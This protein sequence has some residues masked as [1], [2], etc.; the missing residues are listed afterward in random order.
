[1]RKYWLIFRVAISE[2]LVYRADF[3]ISTF[4]RF[5]PIITTVLLWRAIYDGSGRERVGNLSYSEMV[6]YYLFVMIVRA[7]GSMPRLATDVATDIRDG[8][9][10]RYLLQPIDYVLYSM[11]LR[12]AHKLVYFV[13]AAGP[14]AI[15]FWMCRQYLPGWPPASTLAVS[16][17]TLTLAFLLGFSIS[18]SLGLLGFWFLE[19]SSFIH[20]FMI[21]QYFLGGHMFPLS[22]LPDSVRTVLMWLPFAYETYYPTVILLQR[23]EPAEI[24]RIIAM[25]VMWVITLLIF[26]RIAWWRGLR[27]YAAFGG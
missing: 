19:V 16:L 6:S 14:Y 1:M 3:F 23:V 17:V 27:R 5:I 13:M 12:A 15:V 2:R 22:L 8:G 4:L 25:Q 9:L 18:M 7:F 21:V 11:V 10:R 24:T 26:A 20:I